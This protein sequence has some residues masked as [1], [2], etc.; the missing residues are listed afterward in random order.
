MKKIKLKMNVVS[1]TFTVAVLACIILFN[2]IFGVIS[3]KVQMDIDLTQDK[4]YEFSELTNKT[5]AS[6]KEDVNAYMLKYDGIEYAHLR[7]QLEKYASLS[8]KFRF[9]TINPYESPEIMAKFKDIYQDAQNPNLVILECGK[10][11][12]AITY[13]EIFPRSYNNEQSLDGERQI[14]NGLRYVTGEME[15]SVIH[16]TKGHNEGSSEALINL[17]IEEGYRYSEID[18]RS[19]EIDPEATVVI[20]Y[21]PEEDF[22][23][24]EV[25][26]IKDFMKKGGAFYLVTSSRGIYHNLK[27]L[28][29]EWGISLKGEY[30]LEAPENYFAHEN[31]TCSSAIMQKHTITKD[32]IA[33]NYELLVSLLPNTLAVTNSANGA[34]VTPLLMSSSDAYAKSDISMEDVSYTSGDSTGPFVLG[35]ISE[36]TDAANGKLC[37]VSGSVDSSYASKQFITSGA[38][39]N[40]DFTLNLINYMGGTAVESGIR[41]KNISPDSFTLESSETKRITT[42][43]LIWLPLIIFAAGFIVWIRRRFK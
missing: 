6:L 20:S 31:V 42:V 33:A 28:T 24:N 16:F 18:L 13:Y 36:K 29:A 32:L 25:S 11:Y 30:M 38:I 10:R 15:E 4:V 12:R 3:D 26:V 17:M 7:Q 9:R 19:H 21:M 37:V 39:A 22:S 43:L 2:M 14:T 34:V 35:A 5:L 8:S 40:C 1:A 27:A 41:A 23:E